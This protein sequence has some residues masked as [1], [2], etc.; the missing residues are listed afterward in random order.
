MFVKSRGPDSRTVSSVATTFSVGK[1][2]PVITGLRNVPEEVISGRLTFDVT[3]EG[4]GF[5]SGAVGLVNGN[6]QGTEFV[7]ET[8]VIFSI[9]SEDLVEAGD[10]TLSVLNP[11]PTAGPSNELIVSVLNPIAGLRSI[12]PDLIVARPDE[13]SPPIPMTIDGFSFVKGATVLLEG[14][15][16]PTEFVNSTT[17]TA[18]IPAKLV[19]NGE[20]KRITVE[21]PEPVV[22]RSPPSETLPLMVVNPIPVLESLSFAP[23]SFEDDKEFFIDDITEQTFKAL[24]IINGANFNDSTLAFF[25]IPPCMTL[26]EFDG[27][28]GTLLNSN[29]MVFEFSIICS[30]S[31]SITME[32]GQP[33]GGVSK[34]LGFTVGSTPQANAAPN[35]TAISPTSVAAGSATFNMTITGSNFTPSSTVL[36]GTAVLTPTSITSN[37]IVVSVPAILIGSSGVLPITVTDPDGG[38]SNR[39]FFTIP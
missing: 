1:S 33:G 3:V 11:S 19:P 2:S 9:P 12:S 35:I 17:L 38:T 27:G 24:L 22:P 10:L 20:P 32:N 4:T 29:Q 5:E 25:G 26:E 8:E 18:S 34:S 6:P 30:G 14:E 15:A 36:L 37:Q 31:W 7:D 13:S 21:N 39:F 28:G 16:V 23:V